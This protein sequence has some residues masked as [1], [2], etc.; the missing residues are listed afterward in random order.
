MSFIK[1][2]E[3]YN[4]GKDGIKVPISGYKFGKDGIIVP[5]DNN[6]Y[7]L[8]KDGV[9]IPKEGY[10]VG[11]GGIIVKDDASSS[12]FK[13]GLVNSHVP[14]LGPGGTQQQFDF[15]KSNLILMIGGQ[16]LILVLLLMIV[17]FGT[18]PLSFPA[19]AVRKMI[20]SSNKR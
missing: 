5:V 17:L 15:S 7:T 10:H 11:K 8:G 12:S 19:N 13:T 9:I 1:Q 16:I 4:L 20:N 14:R 2:D 6:S 18:P 3:L